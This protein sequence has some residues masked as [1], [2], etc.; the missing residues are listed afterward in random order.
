MES[1]MVHG[2][3]H[4]ISEL[5]MRGVSVWEWIK[6][7]EGQIVHLTDCIEKLDNKLTEYKASMDYYKGLFEGMVQF[8]RS[9]AEHAKFQ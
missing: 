7:L 9:R 3:V 8:E 6:E 1:T 2:E 5:T 4:V